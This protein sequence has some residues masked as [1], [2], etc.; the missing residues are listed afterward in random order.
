MKKRGRRARRDVERNY[1]R[2]RFI[3]KLRRLADCLEQGQPFR[4]Q[5]AGERITVPAGATI[6]VE[7]ERGRSDEE[8]EL[9]LK[10]QRDG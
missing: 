10:W 9:Q 8:L 3:A 4:I 7:H 6:S 2:S 5:V 1:P